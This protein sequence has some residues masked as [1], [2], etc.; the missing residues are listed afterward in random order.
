MA[1]AVRITSGR[2]SIKLTNKS[3]PSTLPCVTPLGT[4]T[5]FDLA[6]PVLT[7]CYLSRNKS[8]TQFKT[9]VLNPYAFLFI[10]TGQDSWHQALY[11]NQ[12]I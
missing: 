5:I 11:K 4:L 1:T 2:S 3:G 8:D 9:N 12:R 7:N 10:I 6:D